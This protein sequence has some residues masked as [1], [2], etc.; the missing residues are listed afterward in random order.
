MVCYP[1]EKKGGRIRTR[2]MD[3]FSEFT[4]VNEHIDFRAKFTWSTKQDRVVLSRIDRFLFSK[5]W[6]DHFVGAIQFALSRSLSN[7]RPI[8]LFTEE[9]D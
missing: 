2:S 1:H 6:E 5:D 9:M 8:K 4:T 3:Y 7:H